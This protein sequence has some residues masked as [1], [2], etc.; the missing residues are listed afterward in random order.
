MDPVKRAALFIRMNELLVQSGAVIPIARRATVNARA[1]A[2][3]GAAQSF[4]KSW[5]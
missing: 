5:P 4:W 2:I 1:S 3:K